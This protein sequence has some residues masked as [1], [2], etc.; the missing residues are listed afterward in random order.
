MAVPPMDK[1]VGANSVRRNRKKEKKRERFITRENEQQKIGFYSFQP[2]G[3][4]KDEPMGI[5]T[6]VTGSEGR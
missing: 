6:P 3:E 1:K 5:R 2:T 4:T